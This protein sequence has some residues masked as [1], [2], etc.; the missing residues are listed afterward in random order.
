MGLIGQDGSVCDARV[1]VDGDVQVLVACAAR[2]ACAVVVDAVSG[3]DDAR[4]ALDVEVDEVTRM[5]VLVAHHRRRRVSERSRFMPF[6]RRI[7]LTVARL[8]PTS[9]AMRQPL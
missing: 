3:L 6:L 9:R 2:L 5:R 7:R 4:Q 8:T 1:I